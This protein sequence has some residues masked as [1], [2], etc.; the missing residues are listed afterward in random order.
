M[1]A[2]VPFTSAATCDAPVVD[3]VDVVDVVDVVDAV[4]V[5]AI[6]EP[7]ASV[8]LARGPLTAFMAG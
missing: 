1:F 8:A 6:G 5:T 4:D 7:A 2:T 3:I